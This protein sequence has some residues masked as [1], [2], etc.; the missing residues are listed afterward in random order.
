MNENAS[1]A[2]PLRVLHVITRM[3]IGGAQENTLFTVI[4]QQGDP[5]FHVTLLC[6]TETGPEGQLHDQARAARVDLV[7]LPPL[8]REVRPLTDLRALIALTRFMRRGRYD[9]VHTHSAKGGILGRIAAHLNRVPVIVHT[10]HGLPFHEFQVEWKNWLII[11]AKRFCARFTDVIIS[12]SDKT[13]E[14]ALAAGVGRRE[15]HVTVYSGMDLNPFIAAHDALTVAEA[16]RRLGIAPED[17]VVGKIAR[18]F[19][20]KGHDQ[21]FDAAGEIARRHPRVRF[22]LVGGGVLRA[23]LEARAAH[24]GIAERVTFAGLVS[25]DQIPLYLQ[26]MDVVVHTSLREGIARVLPQAG[27]MAKPV[28]T[29]SLDGAPEVVRD[30]VS[31][32]LVPPLDTSALAARVVDLLGDPARRNAFGEEGRAFALA[33]FG[34][35]RMVE[36]INEVYLRVLARKAPRD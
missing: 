29:F 32:Y 7:L 31:G 1:R 30:G 19:P 2:R 20:L 4:G 26:A 14:T 22:L 10:Q 23:E 35:D 9:I 15:Q 6:G 12:V 13:A 11:R 16:K 28:V 24:M 8:V 33:N 5:R 21:F 17:L 36:R 25:P 18:L 34:A 3:I 27:V